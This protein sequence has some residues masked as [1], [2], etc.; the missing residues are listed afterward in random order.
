MDLK[1]FYLKAGDLAD[2][3]V[4]GIKMDQWND[5]SN[6]EKWTVRDLV[7]HLTGENFWVS[8]LLLGKTVSEVGNVFDGDLLK[9]DPVSVWKQS[10]DESNS[11][12]SDLDN[13]ERVVHLS[14]GDFPASEYLE[15]L[16]LDRTIHGFDIAKSTG[17][18][19]K[20]P[21]FLV[22]HIYKV[23]LPRER[24]LR[25]SGA[26]GERKKVSDSADTQIKLLAVLGRD[27]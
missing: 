16:I 17:Q 25:E 8:E 12:V 11:A 20:L 5:Q 14:F 1:E 2:R 7:N 9:D 13:L 26:F 22:E 6:C 27:A 18:E 4:S 24:E 21:D 10:L 23:F 19:T 15:Q 3:Y